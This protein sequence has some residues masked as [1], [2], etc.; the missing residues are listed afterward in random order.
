MIT[1]SIIQKSQ[2]EGALRIDAEYYQPEY[3]ELEKALEKFGNKLKIFRELLKVENSLTGGA[4]PLGA[5][6]PK[7]GIKFLRVQNI[8][9]GYL[10]FSDIVYIGKE[11]HEGQLNRSKL[12]DGDVLL[13]ITGVSY[14]KSAV[15]NSEFGESNINQHSVRMHFKKEILPEFIAAYLNSKYGRFQSDRKITGNTRPALAYEEIRQYKI[16]LLKIEQQDAIKNLYDKSLELREKSD[17]FYLQAENLL[18]EELDLKDFKLDEQSF[19]V[20][21]FF[22]AEST[23]R[24]DA[25]YFQPKYN[26]LIAKIKRSRLLGELVSFKKGVE[27]GSEQYQEKGRPFFRV[28]NISKFG[29]KNADKYL[30]KEIYENLKDNYQLEQE[31]ILLTKDATPGVAY[32][33]K[34]QINGII[35]SGILRLRLKEKVEP[36]YLTLVINSII[37]QMQ[38]KRDIGGSVIIHWRPEQIKNILIPI[39]SKPTQ[40]KIADLVQKSHQARKKAKQLLEQAKTKVEELIENN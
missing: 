2:F 30:S 37:G 40:Q 11:I 15:F 18:L 10:D 1:Y 38:M 3:L 26:E 23:N 31:D 28:S 21:N 8:M 19:Y 22:D 34:E 7:E 32:Y 12:I 4:T 16:P 39:L 33:A 14:G 36:E 5:E 27:V 13:T 6:Y 25:E 24:I 20:V 17:N 35:A 29:L 9:P